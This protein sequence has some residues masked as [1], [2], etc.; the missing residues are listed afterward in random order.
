MRKGW[1]REK[2]KEK[3]EKMS[4]AMIHKGENGA[5][6]REKI[7]E[8]RWVERCE[9]WRSETNAGV[10][11]AGDDRQTWLPK[12][13]GMLVARAAPEHRIHP[14]VSPDLSGEKSPGRTPGNQQPVRGTTMET[15]PVD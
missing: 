1:G 3:R 10:S 13:L 14:V 5:C 12:L 11:P 6:G 9:G 4:A 2:S 7:R 15:I 8:K